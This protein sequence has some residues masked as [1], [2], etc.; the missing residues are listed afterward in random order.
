MSFR[1]HLHRDDDGTYN[2][3][4]A[5]RARAAELAE[6]PG[7]IAS[8]AA[9]A[10]AAERRRFEAGERDRRN[11]Q[12]AGQM[13]LSPDLDLDVL[14]PLGDNVAVQLGDMN[15]ERIRVR[16]D[17]EADNHAKHAE[18]FASHRSFWRDTLKALTAGQTIRDA[19]GGA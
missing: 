15:A 12:I 14:I 2:F 6:S 5:E 11:K 7:D 1:D 17:L 16:M 18:S 3:G 8:L 10:A 9:K 4:A 19:V 13:A